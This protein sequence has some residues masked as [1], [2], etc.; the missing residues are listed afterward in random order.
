MNARNIFVLSVG[1]S[2]VTLCGCEF[3][4]S[5]A[6]DGG[7]ED[8]SSP[9]ARSPDAAVESPGT[10]VGDDAD[11]KARPGASQDEN[12]AGEDTE[13]GDGNDGCSS[14]CE[15]S[16][17]C[18]QATALTAGTSQHAFRSAGLDGFW[19]HYTLFPRQAL[20]LGVTTSFHGS[21]AL[22]VSPDGD[23]ARLYGQMPQTAYLQPSTS[24]ATSAVNTGASP[25]ELL[26]QVDSDDAYGSF[27]L[28]ASV[29]DACEG[30]D[31]ES[32]CGDGSVDGSEQCDDANLEPGDGCSANCVRELGWGCSGEPSQCASALPGDLSEGA[33][34]LVDGDFTLAGYTLEPACG[35]SPCAGSSRWFV[36]DVADGNVLWVGLDSDQLLDGEVS[37]WRDPITA[38]AG[39][40]QPLVQFAFGGPMNR[41]KAAHGAAWQAYADMRIFV[42]V[43]DLGHNPSSLNFQLR[44]KLSPYKG[45]GDGLLD[46]GWHEHSGGCHGATPCGAFPE[47]C[48]DANN[49]DG[50]GCDATCHV[51]AG[52]DCWSGPCVQP[53]CGDG[54]VHASEEC[55]DGAHV[56]GDG[57]SADCHTEPGY[58]CP[59]NPEPC[60]LYQ[61]GDACWNA[62]ALVDGEYAWSGYL[63]DNHCT[64]QTPPSRGFFRQCRGADRWFDVIVPAGQTLTVRAST[65]E[66]YMRF[67]LIDISEN[68]AG[69]EA[70]LSTR[71]FTQGAPATGSYFNTSDGERRLAVAFSLGGQATSEHFALT[72]TL[73][74]TGCGDGYIDAFGQHGAS[75]GCDDGNTADGDGCSS[76]CNVE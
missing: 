51:E 47:P 42:R 2:L 24:A 48:D 65:N 73:A 46:E 44:H 25:L 71:D 18:A 21:L 70:A 45:C 66:Q 7:A 43:S 54:I 63:A 14:T 10:S 31:C 53:S 23:C 50:D 64:L 35:A 37:F 56:D 1:V 36:I 22:Y 76:T 29:V 4:P 32:S 61:P 59:P 49:I 52:W 67:E 39:V 15:A 33:E 34:P 17:S 40:P 57:C 8:A 6:P 11:G 55:D 5:E 12:D 13:S 38:E 41:L 3:A 27:T 9:P 16:A 72:H 26:I 30:N 60:A 74:P 68:C 58:L 62:E 75:E 69:S 19:Y 20:H 28:E